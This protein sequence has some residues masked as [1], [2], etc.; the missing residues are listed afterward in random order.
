MVAISMTLPAH[1]SIN[2]KDI[3]TII[4]VSDHARSKEW[5]S[6]LFGKAPD[7]EPFPGNIEYMLGNGWVQIS[8]AT[9]KPSNWNLHIEVHDL[10]KEHRRL[11]DHG[12][13]TSEIGTTHGVI[14][15]FDIKDPDGN[16]MR[17]FQV[18]TK[19]PKVT[20]KSSETNLR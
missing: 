4:P 1:E 16:A 18:L 2:V 10:A 20:G 3:I 17:W 5:Y 11:L 7:L 12:I 14:T 9:V 15:W 13:V 8:K 6:K 19:D